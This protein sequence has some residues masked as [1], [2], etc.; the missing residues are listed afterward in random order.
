MNETDEQYLDGQ[1]AENDYEG[2]QEFDKV[3]ALV[4]FSSYTFLILLGF[5]LGL[6]LELQNR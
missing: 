6:R 5:K 4:H 1:M 3:N 2:G